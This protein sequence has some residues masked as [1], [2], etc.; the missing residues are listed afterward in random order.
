MK[1]KNPSF[2]KT[3]LTTFCTLLLFYVLILVL[4]IIIGSLQELFTTGV[5]QPIEWEGVAMLA[6]GIS[7]IFVPLTVFFILYSLF[8]CA[9]SNKKKV[10]L[11]YTF[12]YTLSFLG[13]CII[14][15]PLSLS[16]ANYLGYENIYFY[17]IIKPTLFAFVLGAILFLLAHRFISRKR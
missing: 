14:S 7:V 13:Y 3:F 1:Q 9:I 11:K 12:F 10:S 5:I 15:I 16:I 2:L 4:P 17:Q 6:L 8:Y